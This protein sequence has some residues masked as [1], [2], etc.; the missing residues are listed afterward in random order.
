[1]PRYW[2]LFS[3]FV[4]SGLS[5]VTVRLG[6]GQ[7]D[8]TL[9]S[10]VPHPKVIVSP[11]I[12]LEGRV[13][14]LYTIE[15]QW[16][17]QPYKPTVRMRQPSFRERVRLIHHKLAAQDAIA[18]AQSPLSADAPLTDIPSFISRFSDSLARVSDLG[19][20]LLVVVPGG[21]RGITFHDYDLENSWYD[22]GRNLPSGWQ[23]FDESAIEI[24]TSFR[25]II[26]NDIDESQGIDLA[27]G[28]DLPPWFDGLEVAPGDGQ[29]W[30]EDSYAA[31]W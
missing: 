3:A 26:S 10:L 15:G 7:K 9:Q 11:L 2:F 14:D 17:L 6:T 8:A 28:D 22:D 13:D 5:V 24:L 29:Y 18:Q 27:A 12:P 1:M 31:W 16:T 23:Y 21:I 4:L 19:K 30:L 20:E 25:R